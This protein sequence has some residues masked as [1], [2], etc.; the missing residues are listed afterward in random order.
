M[1]EFDGVEN[2]TKPKKAI[3]YLQENVDLHMVW[4]PSCLQD[5][6]AEHPWAG[7]GGGEGEPPLMSPP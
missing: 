6:L 4:G 1:K 3:S 5:G 2:Q 7:A